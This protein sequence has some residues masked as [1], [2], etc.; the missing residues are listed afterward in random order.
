MQFFNNPLTN[1]ITM[2]NTELTIHP[3]L[4]TL[5]PRLTETEFAGL[6]ESILKDG[7]LSPLVVWN[8][9]LIDG[10]HRYEI[11]RKHQI[12]FSVQSVVFESLDDAKLWIWKHQENR[13]NLTAFQRAEIALK[14]KDAVA[15]KAKERQR[16][17][18]GDKKSEKAKSL[19]QTF[20]EAKETR[21]ELA[22]TA[23]VSHTTLNKAEFIA[24]HA[25]EE[26]KAK[27]RRG[28]KGTSINKEY[29]RLKEESKPE[30]GAD[31]FATENSEIK[32]YPPCPNKGE[33]VVPRTTLKEIP[34]DTPQV[35]L[36]NLFAHFRKGFV[37]D[38]VVM[39]MTMLRNKFGK[40]HVQKILRELQKQHGK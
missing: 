10:H 7:C 35:L 6:E 28:E 23:Q 19:P 27:L 37:D 13:R 26:T 12:P 40:Q 33:K 18:G 3:D 34:Q 38:L 14:V 8:N 29:K 9:T 25:D 39:A 21:Q 31:V 22:E 16:A 24:E 2:Q 5:L 11:C 20:A 30:P 17:A 15:A 32:P 1:F 4:E 36:G